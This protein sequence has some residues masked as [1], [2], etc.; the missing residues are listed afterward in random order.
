MKI[1]LQRIATGFQGEFCYT[2]ARGAAAPDGRAVITTQPL[3]LTGSDIFYGMRELASSDGGRNW[4]P[5]REVPELARRPFPGHPEWEIAMADATPFY[6]AATGKFLLTGSSMIY[7]NDEFIPDPRPRHTVWSVM[8]PDDG[9]WSGYRPLMMPH[10][11]EETFF[12]AAAACSQIYEQQDGK[13]LIPIYF[14]TRAEAAT[15]WQ[16]CYR[17][18]VMRCGFDGNELRFLECGEPLSVPEPRGLCEPSIIRHNGRFYLTM[19]NDKTGYVAAGDDGLHYSSPVEWRFDDGEELGNYNTQQH[20]ISGGGR[21]FLVYTRRA[22]DNGH[23]FRHRAP[24]F[25]AEV[26]PD[27]LRVIRSTECIAVPERGA[28]LGNFG[29]C[30]I[31]EGE[32]WI[33]VSEWMQCDGPLGPANWERCMSRGS[34]NSIFIARIRF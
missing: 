12:N 24:L 34:D 30:R 6:H 31:D 3:R 17:A 11:P 15:P 32:S 33:V 16:S 22:G 8:S 4:S 13:L 2:H 10:D 9:T 20:W 19:R 18:A 23:V 28:R 7:C 29:C 5:I 25:L 14:M 26:N 21:L 1:E 27:T